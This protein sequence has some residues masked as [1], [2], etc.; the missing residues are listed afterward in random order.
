MLDLFSDV[1][2]AGEADVVSHT[3][4]YHACALGCGVEGAESLVNAGEYL[5]DCLNIDK[6]VY[7]NDSQLSTLVMHFYGSYGN[8]K[9]TVEESAMAKVLGRL[10]REEDTR[11]SRRSDI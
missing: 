6:S 7:L 10:G 2:R 5:W 3:M 11:G 8:V 1:Q 9:T 4:A